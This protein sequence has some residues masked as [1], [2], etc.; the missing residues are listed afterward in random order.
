MGIRTDLPVV[1]RGW[2]S[3][4]PY[5]LTID[6]ERHLYNLMQLRIAECMSDRGFSYN[7][8]HFSDA[9]YLSDSI[10]PLDKGIAAVYGYHLPPVELLETN[11]GRDQAFFDALEGTDVVPGCGQEGYTKSYGQFDDQFQLVDALNSDIEAKLPL[12]S[13]STQGIAVLGDWSSCMQSKGY[14]FNSPRDAFL[15]VND[16]GSPTTDEI[17]LRM[18]DYDCDVETKLTER[19]HEWQQEI[20]DGWLKENESDIV[21]ATNGREAVERFLLELQ[22][23]NQLES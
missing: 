8:Y 17:V 15:S 23:S 18:A 19:R 10:N 5:T 2:K 13:A 4:F 11:V 20:V 1:D 22:E 7:R 9:D 21:E 16:E 12:F 3:T 6:D 14:S